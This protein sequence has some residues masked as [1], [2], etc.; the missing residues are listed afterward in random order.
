MSTFL[1]PGIVEHFYK[2]ILEIVNYE[3]R[4]ET[5]TT[6]TDKKVYFI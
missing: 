3:Y 5:Q 4:N 2:C 6:G 1:A